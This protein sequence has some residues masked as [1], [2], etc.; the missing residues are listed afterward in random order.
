VVAP[1]RRQLSTLT[2]TFLARFFEN[3]A[4]GTTTDARE[5]FFWL[6]AAL[7]TPGIFLPLWMYFRWAGVAER[8]GMLALHR[9]LLFDKTIYLGVTTVAIALLSAMI[10]HTLIVERRDALILGSLPVRGRTI[11]CAKLAAMTAYIGM[12][13]VGMH[14]IS[15]LLYGFGLSSIESWSLLLRFIAGQIVGALALNVF[16]FASVIGLQNLA[17]AVLGPRRF[18]RVSS[19]LQVLVVGGGVGML[20]LVP[21]MVSST[22]LLTD[23]GAATRAL[24]H[25]IFWAPPL[26]F[27]GLNEVVTGTSFPAMAP[28]AG[29]A[30]FA[31][32]LASVVALIVFPIAAARTMRAAVEGNVASY[33]RGLRH[34]SIW[35][36]RVLAFTAP[37]RGALQFTM[38][39]LTRTHQQRL[40]L[41]VT[42]GVAVAMVAPAAVMFFE[43]SNLKAWQLAGW[44][45]DAPVS[46]LSAPLLWNFAT[47]LGLRTAMAFP[48]EFPASWLFAVAPAPMFVGRN[49][50]RSLLLLVGVA[51]PLLVAAPVWFTVWPWQFVTPAFIACILG[52]LTIVD[53]ALWGFV[54]IP[55]AKPLATQRSGLTSR[56]PALLV[57]LYFYAYVFPQWQVA[58]TQ[59]PGWWLML[60][61]PVAIFIGV[62]AGSKSAARANGLSGDPHGY[63]TL[64]LSVSAQHL[65][66]SA[67]NA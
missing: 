66:R 62:H 23:P 46:L 34:V 9:T 55:C 11:T 53:G 18:A 49:A 16:V 64:D 20:L 41:A 28:L 8:G 31:M 15:A 37:R 56:W 63:L 67:P 54:G 47:V 33:S 51:L 27:L 32:G 26:W 52:M 19:L 29:R 21:A 35:L 43:G 22:P 10:W 58:A 38:A 57:F 65:R 39:A 50:A 40:I 3:E 44:G 2:R 5:G 12:L 17:I 7:A 59:R 48:S 4:A 24:T 13:S 25:A 45:R 6:I 42:V 36:T 60:I 61:P 1:A 14:A 30:L